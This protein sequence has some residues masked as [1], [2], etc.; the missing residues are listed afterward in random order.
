VEIPLERD[1]LLVDPRPV[2]GDDVDLDAA[3]VAAARHG[4]R[5][6]FGRLYDR[7]APMVHGILLSRVRAQEADDLLHEVFLAALDRLGALRDDRAFGGW[8]ATIARNHAIDHHRRGR[9]DDELPAD[10]AAPDR[11]TVEALAVL[12]TI[13]A[14]PEAYRETLVLRL[15]EG[16]TGPEIAAR[17]GM[18][19]AS[20]R[21]N[22]HRGMRRLRERLGLAPG[23][24]RG[25][26]PEEN[27]D[28]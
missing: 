6:A 27:D 20:V 10:C 5:E 16:L 15:V 3:L 4:D 23:E 9:R 22:L 28:A 21:V 18:T 8:L 7:F 25:Q 14:L 17:C 12:E 24:R 19:H 1:A 13:R 26:G 2:S 11:A